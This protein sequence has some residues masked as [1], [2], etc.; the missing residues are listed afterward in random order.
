MLGQHSRPSASSSFTCVLRGP[1]RRLPSRH[2]IPSTDV[3]AP[4]EWI[5][6]SGWSLSRILVIVLVIVDVCLS[7]WLAACLRISTLPLDEIF[8]SICPSP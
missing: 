6:S 7:L 2:A 1:R 4:S 8:R 3:L 5:A